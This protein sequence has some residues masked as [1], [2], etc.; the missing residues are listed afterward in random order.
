[1]D[2]IS[3]PLLA[4]IGPVP[5]GLLVEKPDVGGP[6]EDVQEADNHRHVP[7]FNTQKDVHLKGGFKR[8]NRTLLKK[9]HKIIQVHL[10]ACKWF[11]A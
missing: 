10:W 6:E 3:N 4:W 5:L 7:L 9:N 1:M 8:D 11:L 2:R